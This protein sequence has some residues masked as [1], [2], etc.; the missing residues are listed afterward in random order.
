MPVAKEFPVFLPNKGPVLNKPQE[1]LANQFSP[2]SRNMQFLNELLQGRGGLSK[3]STT[4]LSGAVQTIANFTEVDGTRFVLFGTPK[5]IY[6]YD[7]GNSRFDILT[8]LYQTGKI[9]VTNAST[10]VYGGLELDNCDTNPV[11]WVDGSGG[12][13]TVSRETSDKKDGTASVKLVVAASAG[14]EILA[15]HDITPVD[16]HAYDSMG[17]WFKSTVALNAGDLQFL[18]DNTAACVSPLETI[19]FPAVTANTWTW[20]PLPFVTPAALTAVAS[21][22]I[23]QA[24]DKGAMTLYIDQIVVGDW[25]DQLKA[26]D[27][28]KVGAGSVHTGSTWYTIAS[29]DSDTS[30]TLTAV[31]AGSTASQQAYVARQTFTGGTTDIW[32]WVQFSD[33]VLGEVLLMTNGSSFVYWTGS[34]QAVAVSGLPSGFTG[35][36]FISVYGGRVLVG[37]TVEGGQNQ[38]QRVRWCDPANCLSWQDE[39]FKDF[40]DEPTAVNGMT[41]FNGFHIVFKEEEAYIGR[42]V[43]GDVIFVWEI[44]SQAFG[45]RSA[46]SI[47]TRKD[48]IYY[49]ANDKKFHRFNLLQDE[50]ISES[51]FPETKEFD[52]NTDEFIQ[53]YNVTR[54]NEVRW[55]CP[56]GNTDQMNYIFV[57]NYQQNIPQ[58]WEYE[59]ADALYSMGSYFRTS[60]VYADDAIYGAQYADESG[61]YADDSTFL[62]DS[63]IVIYGGYDGI[64]RIADSGLTDDGT[65]FTRILRL[66]RLNF[67]LINLVKRLWKQIW[68]LEAATVG[69]VTVKMRLDDRTTYEPTTKTISLIP[70]DTDKDIVKAPITWNKHAQNF[71]AEISSTDHFAV[72]GVMNLYFPKKRAYAT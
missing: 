29:I 57:W 56:F 63:A 24:V 48:W 7:F 36:K 39:D 1:F 8:P 4:A 64:V 60:D 71:Q 21:I 62:Q 40:T 26:G 16:I 55:A 53:G 45:A 25:N 14:V 69:S 58:V 12:D 3:F 34:G 44:S 54:S 51:I 17:F 52:P 9:L 68:W 19:N 46:W 33:D 6:A 72:L 66:K 50:P 11:A 47:V 70:V 23:K 41:K 35:A 49:Y 5:D 15:Y 18:L 59:Q 27:F 38:I 22:G 42:F 65:A 13:V 43:G 67:G 20:V 61:G 2:Y 31:Y 10:K 32:D 37:W 28:I 30:M